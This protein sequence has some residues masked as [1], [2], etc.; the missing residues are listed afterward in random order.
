LYSELTFVVSA[1][2]IVVAVF[3]RYR[4]GATPDTIRAES[5]AET[6]ER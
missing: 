5:L 6:E 2:F 4:D 3:Y 1:L